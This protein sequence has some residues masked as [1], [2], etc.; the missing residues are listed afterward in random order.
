MKVNKPI[1]SESVEEQQLNS[2]QLHLTS[3]DKFTRDNR[4]QMQV[5]PS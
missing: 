4:R 3:K 2:L 1:F 5:K